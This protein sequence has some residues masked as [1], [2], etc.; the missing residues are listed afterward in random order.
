LEGDVTD[1]GSVTW[2]SSGPDDIAIITMANEITRAPRVLTST[3]NS[4]QY[5]A[6]PRSTITAVI[7]L[8]RALR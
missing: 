7:A 5:I 6:D 2:R 3:S 1:A 8:K 4:Q